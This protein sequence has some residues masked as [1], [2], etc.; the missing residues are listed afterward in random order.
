MN[1]RGKAFEQEEKFK[2]T[3]W[4]SAVLAAIFTAPEWIVMEETT[5]PAKR[6]GRTSMSVCVE[7]AHN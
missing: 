1:R 2:A 4:I 5:V 3:R 7:H 6:V